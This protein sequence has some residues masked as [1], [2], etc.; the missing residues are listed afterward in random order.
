VDPGLTLAHI[1]LARA[2]VAAGELGATPRAVRRGLKFA[3]DDREGS[4]MEMLSRRELGARYDG[5]GVGERAMP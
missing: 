4:Q 1:N 3:P 2:Y 5:W